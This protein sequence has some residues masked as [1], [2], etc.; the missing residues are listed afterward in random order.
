MNEILHGRLSQPKKVK[1]VQR[2]SGNY[3]LEWVPSLVCFEC[4]KAGAYA[5]VPRSTEY[6]GY[7]EDCLVKASERIPY[8]EFVEVD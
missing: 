8:I 4:K 5:S 6:K 2:K 3:Q 1:V 7:C